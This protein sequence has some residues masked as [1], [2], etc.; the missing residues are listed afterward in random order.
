[1]LG[2]RC[3]FYPSCGHYA[4]EAFRAHGFFRGLW[5]SAVRVAKCSPLHPGGHDPV[6]APKQGGT[7][8][9]AGSTA[10]NIVVSRQDTTEDRAA[11]TK[12]GA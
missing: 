9:P 5:L 8:A 4:E 12:Q 11:S 10:L 1:M 6:P 2:S 3:R 7:S